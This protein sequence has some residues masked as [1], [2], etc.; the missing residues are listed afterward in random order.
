[1][2]VGC[3]IPPGLGS[4]AQERHGATRAG[5]NEGCEDDQSVGA[6]LLQRK[7]VGAGLVQCR[8]EKAPG[9]PFN[10]LS[11]L[12]DGRLFIGLCSNRTRSWL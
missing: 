6:P 9:R 7:A 10:G 4:P 3:F 11:V 1:M 12:K 8:E 5:P 2:D